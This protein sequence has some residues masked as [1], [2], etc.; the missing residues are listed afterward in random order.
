MARKFSF[1]LMSVFR[2]GLGDRSDASC[3]ERNNIHVSH[4]RACGAYFGSIG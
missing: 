2:L 3:T 4:A 1:K